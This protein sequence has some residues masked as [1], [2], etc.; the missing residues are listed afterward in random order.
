MSLRCL[1]HLA[2]EKQDELDVLVKTCAP[3]VVACFN[4]AVKAHVNN[5]DTF[6]QNLQLPFSTLRLMVQTTHPEFSGRVILCAVND[7]LLPKLR[8]ACYELSF[9]YPDDTARPSS[10]MEADGTLV[11]SFASW[12]LFCEDSL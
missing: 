1:Y 6:D 5:I 2:A 12:N 8:D 9:Q 3:L 7:V 10:H 11:V 4:R